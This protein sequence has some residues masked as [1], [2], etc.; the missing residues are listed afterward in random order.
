MRWLV[1]GGAGYIGAHVLRS[2]IAVGHDAI[3]LDDLST[4]IRSRVGSTIPFVHGDIHDES[5]LTDVL[6]NVDGV[7]HLAG[8]KSVSE[9]QTQPMRYWHVNVSGTLS[10]LRAMRYSK[11]E[12]LIFSSTASV[13]GS[14]DHASFSETSK[15]AP[16]S[17]YGMTKLS[18]ER[19][20]HHYAAQYP[21]RHATLRYFN[22]GGCGHPGLHDTSADNVIPT[23]LR[24]IAAG[25][26]P[27]IYGDDYPTSDGT[28]VRDYV[29]VSDIAD[30]HAAIA[31]RLNAGLPH[32]VYN[33]GTGK[34]VTVAELAHKCLTVTG[35]GAIP[36]IEGRRVGDSAAAVADV[37]RIRDD[38]G[39]FATRTVDD[40]VESAWSNHSTV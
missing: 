35:S 3:V 11:I 36:L 16:K 21:L 1:T 33:V 13:Y 4:G 23:F 15:V 5:L 38:V 31:T 6:A 30:A 2:L 28:C 29:H 18:A 20:I 39:W 19:M 32:T 17:V 10:L 12:C 34:G 14:T 24:R 26:P 22:V 7:I 25:K 27:I 37:A 9:S 40:V 8:L